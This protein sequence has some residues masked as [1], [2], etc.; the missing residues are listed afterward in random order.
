M[1]PKKSLPPKDVPDAA[2]EASEPTNSPQLATAPEVPH[3]IAKQY[4][5]HK[6]ALHAPAPAAPEPAAA[7]AEPVPGD[8]AIENPDIDAAVDAIVSKESDELLALQG[9][10]SVPQHT[11]A[12][13]F[14]GRLK[15]FFRAWWRNKWARYATIIGIAAAITTL[16]A[17]PTTRYAILNACGVRSSAKVVVLDNTTRLPLKNVTVSI[18]GQKAQTNREG[19]V[20]ISGLKL[21]NY[22]LM[23]KRLAFAPYSQKVTIGWGSNPLGNISLKAVGTQYEILVKDFLSDKPVAGAEVESDQVNALSDNQG[24][25]TLTVA[26]TSITTLAVKLNAPG[27]RSET[28]QLTADT[29]KQTSVSLVPSQK[30]VFVRN[31]FGKYDVYS[32]DLDGKDTKLL[33]AGTGLENAAISLAVSADNTQAA[34][35]STRDNLRDSDGYL[36]RAL[37]FI[38]VSAGT[39]VTVDHAQQLQLV[40]WLGARLVYRST[41]ASASAANPQ[42]NRLVAYNYQTNARTQLATANQFNTIVSADGYLYYSASSNDP[43]AVVGLFRVKPDGLTRERLSDREVWTGLRSAI[44]TLSLQTPEGWFSFD[45]AS[46]K[47]QQTTAPQTFVSSY[48]ASDPKNTSSAWTDIRNGQGVLLLKKNESDQVTVLA[49]QPGLVAPVHWLNDKVL[50]YRVVTSRESADYAVSTDGGA[51]HKISNVTATDNYIQAY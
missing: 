40:D 43:S 8:P 30:T 41:A 38:N 50:I 44:G 9:D 5:L 13:G 36:L 28:L 33:L 20:T 6:E 29:T 46:K 39:S 48:F 49:T 12:P 22:Q 51:P 19:L 18:G 37:T 26:D 3:A 21:G 25:V 11:K 31:D 27:Y 2:S 34:L 45:L 16:T 4:G 15:R 23:V 32:S 24:K 1:T 35:V 17:M 10:T 47:L 7:E 42:R 14:G